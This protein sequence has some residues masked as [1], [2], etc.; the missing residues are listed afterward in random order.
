MTDER[1]M[2]HRDKRERDDLCG[3]GEAGAVLDAV[4]MPRRAQRRCGYLGE[5]GE[6]MLAMTV[7]Q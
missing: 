1:M 6:W 5:G 2:M 4:V 7:G 3:G